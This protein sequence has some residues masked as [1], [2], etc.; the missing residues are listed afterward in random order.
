MG[1]PSDRPTLEEQIAWLRDRAMDAELLRQHLIH[2]GN[3]NPDRAARD[4]AMWNAVLTT[5]EDLARSALRTDGKR[6]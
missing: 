1:S 3:V 6:R 2:S 4:V 5:L